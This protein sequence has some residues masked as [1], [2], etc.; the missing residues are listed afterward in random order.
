M[1]QREPA[2]HQRRTAHDNCRRP[3]HCC[4]GWAGHRERTTSARTPCD[5]GQIPTLSAVG[6][7]AT[8]LLAGLGLTLNARGNYAGAF[9]LV[10][11]ADAGNAPRTRFLRPEDGAW[12]KKDRN[13]YFFVTTNTMDAAKDGDLNPDISA[14]QVGRSRLWALKFKDS[15]KPELG[16]T[17]EVEALAESIFPIHTLEIVQGGR[18]VAATSE[19]GGARRLVLRTQIKV[20][21]N[22]WLATRVGGPPGWPV[23]LMMPP[24]AWA[25]MSWAGRVA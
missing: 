5:H 2:G 20:D 17:I 22:T 23:R 7:L 13:R 3:G 1:V 15:S 6:N 11:G 8:W 21:S 9:T 18:V 16:G 19:P 10:E 14:G 24:I 25:T 4:P 12:D